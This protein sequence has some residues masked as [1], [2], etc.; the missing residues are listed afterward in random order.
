MSHP[1]GVDINQ[2]NLLTH[3]SPTHSQ[4]Y[5]TSVYFYGFYEDEGGERAREVSGFLLT[6]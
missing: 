1:K 5:E 6:D 4:G 3:V 2:L